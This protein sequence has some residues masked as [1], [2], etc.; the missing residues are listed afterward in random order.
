MGFRH[1]GQGPVD[2][3]HVLCAFLF[4]LALAG[5]GCAPKAAGPGSAGMQAPDQQT[6][7]A[8]VTTPEN[9]PVPA[10]PRE[11]DFSAVFDEHDHL[12]GDMSLNGDVEDGEQEDAAMTQDSLESVEDVP[13]VSDIVLAQYEDWQG[14]RY[15]PGGTDYRGVDCSGLVQAIFRDAFEV[16]LPRSSTDQARLGEAVPKGDIRPG[17]LLY[18][19]DRGRKHVGVAVNDRQFI[20]ASRRKGVIISKFE[21]YWSKRLIRVRRILDEK[22]QDALMRKGG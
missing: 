13:S 21:G 12:F 16:D 5:G 22:D 19:I 8:P 9:A 17:D 6:A 10:P 7:C 2:W 20:H 3:L 15:R 11:A 1:S 4:A 14:V 18:F